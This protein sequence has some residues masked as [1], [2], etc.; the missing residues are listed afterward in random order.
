MMRYLPP[1]ELSVPNWLVDN[2]YEF[3]SVSIDD[4]LSLSG[5]ED[6]LYENQAYLLKA[7]N[8][9]SVVAQYKDGLIQLLDINK[10]SDTR[11]PETYKTFDVRQKTLYN[12]L[13]DPNIK[14][15]FAFGRA[16]T[17]KSRTVM[18]Y[19]L[20]QLKK[21]KVDSVAIAKPLVPVSDSKFMGTLPGDE[22]EKTA[23]F[24]Y[25]FQDVA[26]DLGFCNEFNYWLDNGIH[27]QGKGPSIEF[28]ITDFARG[29][30]L[31]HDIVIFDEIQNYNVHEMRT[32]LTR[33]GANTKLIAIG[34][35]CQRDGRDDAGVLRLL[36][37]NRF[38]NSPL[39]ACLELTTRYRHPLA[40]LVEDIL[41][42]EHDPVLSF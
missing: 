39:C 42:E 31:H 1:F 13:E 22:F 28:I 41:D 8:G 34:D 21:H 24:L 15:V 30:T 17:G 35:L 25:S 37:S 6:D 4:T 7:D 11:R 26:K 38:M 19:A 14:A 10:K 27:E 40:A 18:A 20:S 16:G 9:Q 23:P 29:R 2:I 32:M 5:I 3:K 36:T 12:L 33:V